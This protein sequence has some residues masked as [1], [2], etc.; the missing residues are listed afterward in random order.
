MNIK[1]RPCSNSTLLVINIFQHGRKNSTQ[2]HY[3]LPNNIKWKNNSN[4]SIDSNKPLQ[5][6]TYVLLSVTTHTTGCLSSSL[7]CSEWPSGTSDWT[8]RVLERVFISGAS[9]SCDEALEL[10]WWSGDIGS[11]C[12]DLN[13]ETG[14]L[15]TSLYLEL[16]PSVEAI[17]D[18]L[19]FGPSVSD[20]P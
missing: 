17:E 8:L 3:D 18:K 20:S 1:V 15:V 13:D 11:G 5:V 4:N 16:W 9:V 10:D 14:V 2:F 12:F 19:M 6:T 7:F